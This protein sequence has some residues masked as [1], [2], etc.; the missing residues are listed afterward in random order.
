MNKIKIFI[1]TFIFSNLCFA[2][3]EF[4]LIKSLE[5]D[6]VLDG[7]ISADEK[8]NSLVTSI[9]YEQEPGDNIATKL[10]SEVFITYTDTFIYFGVKAYGNPEN[11]RGQVKP[12]DQS[13]YENEDMIFIRIDPFGDSRSN[14]ILG[15]N[16]FGSQVDLRVKNATNEED[17]FDSGYNAVFETKSSIVKDGY[18][19]EF[20]IPINSLPYPPGKNQIWK[21]NI[22]R[23]FTLNGTF[24]RSQTQP[25]DRSDPC[26][27]CQVT[28]KLI[29]KN[30]VYKGKTELLPY[31]SSNITGQRQ[32]GYKDPIKYGKIKGDFGIGLNYDF[33]PSSSI[34][35]TINPDFSQIE[36]DETQIDINSSFALD[37]PELRPFFNKGMDLLKFMDRGF[38]SRTIN[39]PSFSSKFV[40]LGQNS[41]TILLSAID[42]VSPYL[43]GGEDKSYNGNGGISYVNAFRHQRLINEGSKYG[44]FTTNRYFKEGGYGNLIGIDG[45]FTFNKIWR[46]QFELSKSFNKEP[47][48]NWIESDETFLDKT[49]KL[50]GE[51]F[52]GSANY[53]RLSRNTEHWNTYLF[54]KGI[55][56]G[57]R[58][59]VGFVPRINRRYGSIYQ[60]YTSFFDKKYLKEFNTS[61]KGDINYNYDNQLKTKNFEFNISIKT[62]GKTEIGYVYEYNLFRKYLNIDF[63]HYGK[64]R[65]GIRGFP[66]EKLTFDF[67]GKIGKEIAFNEVT[68]KI[69]EEKTIFFSLAYKLGYNIN[70]SSSINY[71]RLENFKNNKAIYDGYISRLSFRYQFN[72]DFSIR[73]VSEYNKFNDTFLLQPLIKWNPN[74]STIFYIGGIQNSINSFELEPEDF[75]PF[76]VNKSQ[77][78]LKF[79]YLIGI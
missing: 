79:Q 35:A 59:D 65:I 38:Y 13:E 77:F 75:D 47:I 26:W 61:L 76:R 73:L 36:A 69:G 44:F 41:G 67:E 6:I 39:S 68:P 56:P 28:D 27:V 21:F 1:L 25:Y 62:F 52:K 43:I 7:I 74:P 9:D 45:L 33:S 40:N 78:F 60:G 58:A 23:V 72:N 30:I 57:F 51:N 14:Y 12:R 34:E 63:K 50:D 8:R 55:S 10:Q 42:E 17:S 15:S 71:S 32:T 19:L 64:S 54:Y 2:Q 49:V 16:A 31:I 20:K 46:F 70:V 4:N 5:N 22:S 66:T 48:A 11:I 18:V 3:K 29:M 24:Y 53:I 37:Y